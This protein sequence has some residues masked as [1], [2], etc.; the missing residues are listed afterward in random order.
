ME[1]TGVRPF[2]ELQAILA[3]LKMLAEKP[4][5]AATAPP[6]AVYT[7]DAV[8]AL[9]QERIFS[10]AWLCA[11]RSDELAKPGDY[12]SF[13][14]GDQ[15]LIIIRG[16]DGSLSALANICRH[17]MMRL[18]EGRGNAR[19]FTCPYHAWTYNLEGQL[20]AAAH[21]EKTECF[22]KADIRLP[23]ARCEEYLGWI[24]VSLD[25][26]AEPVADCLAELTDRLQAYN[27]QNYVTIFTEDH[28]WDTNWKCLTENFM[29][30]YHLPV[31]HK[32]TVGAYFPVE[33]TVFD[34][35]GSFPHFTSQLFKKT[36]NA[37]VGTAH[38]ANTSLEGEWRN[39]SVMPTVFPCHMYVLAPDHL[40]YLALQPDGVGKTRIRY[41]AAIAPEVLAAQSDPEAYIANAK[42]F[43]D[44]VQLE[45][46]HVV[47][48]IFAGAKAP[49]SAPGPLSWL[50]RENHEFTQY[51][52]RMLCD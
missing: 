11:G 27:M 33:E 32:G 29:E 42:A 48:G 39:I 16:N 24:Y 23:A 22:N 49:M 20:V 31:A 30:G 34:D 41:G 12:M 14:H 25:A 46:K 7:S 6:K 38:P 50:E 13:E 19:R 4:L 51:L 18:V 47:E 26:D 5:S 2:D 37:P 17:R 52:A 3:D 36:S 1:T 9:E 28:V 40:W 15:P 21:M 44:D 45:D 43:L 35:R 8:A 10:K